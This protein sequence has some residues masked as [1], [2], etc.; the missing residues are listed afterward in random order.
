MRLTELM[1][2]NTSNKVCKETYLITYK[3]LFYCYF[4]RNNANKKIE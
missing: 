1:T 3:K 4:E 2:E